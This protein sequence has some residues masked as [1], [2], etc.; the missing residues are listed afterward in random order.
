PE[1]VQDW[2]DNPTSSLVT[3]KCE[4][5]NYKDQILILGDASHAIVPFYGQGMNSGFEDCTVFEQIMGE[6]EDW[7]E[8]FE[9]FSRKRKPD[10]DA[11]AELAFINH[12]EMRDKTG[13]PKFL[14]QKK[15]E[16]R[17]FEKH[18]EKW[19]PLYSQVTFSNIP[20]ADALNTGLKQQKIMDQVM[21]DPEI[22]EKWDSG[23]IEEQI[24]SLIKY[25]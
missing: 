3:I 6:T 16:S 5:W 19:M 2:H 9:R 22:K 15:I 25:T 11:I 21:K 8:R 18:P 20:Y 13:D 1:L 10:T 7:A 17:F 4:P 24:L 12:V 14:L 23:V